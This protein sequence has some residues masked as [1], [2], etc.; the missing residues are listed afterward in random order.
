[1]PTIYVS[2]PEAQKVFD[3]IFSRFFFLFCWNLFQTF[4]GNKEAE[5]LILIALLL[6][7]HKVLS[8][9][10]N[11]STL[12]RQ[13]A[14]FFLEKSAWSCLPWDFSFKQFSFVLLLVKRADFSLALYHICF[15]CSVFLLHLQLILSAI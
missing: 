3:R 15:Y 1:M 12:K 2:F 8:R 13:L 7:H 6:E 5:H 4:M 11:V 9:N 14:S 10:S